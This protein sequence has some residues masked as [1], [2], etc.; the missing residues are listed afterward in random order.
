MSNKV[1]VVGSYNTDLTIKTSRLPQPGETIVGGSF[2]MSAGGKG[3]NQVVAAAR[4]GAATWFIGRVGEDELGQQAIK[5]LHAEGVNCDFVL[6]DRHAPTGTAFIIVDAQGENSI[7][8]A[9]GAN[10]QLQPSDIEAAATVIAA[11][12]VMVLQLETP[13]ETV[14]AAARLAAAHGVQVILNPAPAAVLGESL[15]RHLAVISPNA[16]EAEML[17]GVRLAGEASLVAAAEHL[18]AKGVQAVLITLGSR[19]AFVAHRRLRQLL[20]AFAVRAVDTTAAGDVFSGALSAFLQPSRPLA[21]AVRW[22]AAPAA[23]SVTRMGAMNSAPALSEIQSFLQQINQPSFFE[24]S[25]A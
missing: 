6:R 17:T 3:A 22:A 24:S 18:L 2:T 1:V 25:Q 9:S 15:L 12:E 10:M 20:P 7:V 13:L 21:E 23:L 8:V 16:V 14:E 19:G 11:A 5:R 4:A